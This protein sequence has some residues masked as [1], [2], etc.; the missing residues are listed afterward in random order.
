MLVPINDLNINLDDPS[1]AIAEI[2]SL[3]DGLK[4]PTPSV[5]LEIR[6]ETLQALVNKRQ[7]AKALIEF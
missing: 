2:L 5:W 3:E 6:P 1:S 4:P 7:I